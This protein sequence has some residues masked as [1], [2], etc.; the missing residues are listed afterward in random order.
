MLYQSR[1]NSRSWPAPST[2]KM[3]HLTR[4][5]RNS[6]KAR[7]DLKL[8]NSLTKTSNF[9]ASAAKAVN[10]PDSDSDLESVPGDDTTDPEKVRESASLY[11]DNIQDYH[12]QRR[13]LEDLQ[14]IA[15]KSDEGKTLSVEEEHRWVRVADEVGMDTYPISN[16]TISKEI[17]LIEN[18][19][20]TLEK[21]IEYLY[22]H[23]NG[24]EEDYAGRSGDAGG[25]GNTESV[26]SKRFWDVVGVNSENQ[27]GSSASAS[28]SNPDNQVNSTNSQRNPD[29]Q[30]P[31]E[32]V[33]EIEST[34]PMDLFPGDD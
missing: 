34:S 5:A 29:N 15:D 12:V 18:R 28:N 26:Q 21:K 4:L 25:D 27:S 3:L 33:A 30:T 31:T 20:D 7:R 32:W 1:I 19:I 8:L 22:D 23:A 2:L 10:N 9:S 14:P 24:L 11:E 6:E 17:E 16:E 13:N